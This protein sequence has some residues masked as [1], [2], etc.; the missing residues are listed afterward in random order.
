MT[1]NEAII[2]MECWRDGYQA[3]ID[4]MRV[5][6]NEFGTTQARIAILTCA[7]MVEAAKPDQ[8]AEE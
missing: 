6:A 8:V 2:G 1:P 7:D 5:W 4:S 3:A